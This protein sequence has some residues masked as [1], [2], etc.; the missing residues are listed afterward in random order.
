MNK[1]ILLFAVVL[2]LSFN[3]HSQKE[4]KESTDNEINISSRNL[5]NIYAEIYKLHPEQ[6]EY[7]YELREKSILEN[8]NYLNSLKI[9]DKREYNQLISDRK[10]KLFDCSGI[11]DKNFCLYKLKLKK[12]L[13]V[14][15]GVVERDGSVTEAIEILE[16]SK[17]SDYNS[18]M[19]YKKS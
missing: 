5:Q 11:M 1:K 16:S 17:E 15:S 7:Y 2:T 12:Q 3:A 6:K 4:K 8:F 13:N 10:N 19:K 14:I 18:L 9:N